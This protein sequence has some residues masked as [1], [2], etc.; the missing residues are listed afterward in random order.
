MATT[1]PQCGTEAASDAARHCHEC[2]ARLGS[3]TAAPGDG[4]PAPGE[5]ATTT[6]DPR[7]SGGR[8]SSETR[9]WAM[10]AHLS[11]FLGAWVF[12]AFAGPLVVWLLR[13]DDDPFV[14]EHAREALNFNLNLLLWLTAAIVFVVA[15]IGFGVLVV[16]PIGLVI[17]LTWLILT[18]VAAVKASNG[19]RYRY[20]LTIRFVS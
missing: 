12:L 5:P 8:L 1:C 14:A 9:N 7:T 13:R 6:H 15:T 16:V 3:P 19:E 18:V 4:E 11:A 10:A 20:P 17:G 2:G